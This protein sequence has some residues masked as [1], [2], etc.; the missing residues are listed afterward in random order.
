MRLGHDSTSTRV[1]PYHLPGLQPTAFAELAYGSPASPVRLRLPVATPALIAQAAPVLIGARDSYLAALPV[2]RI[3]DAVDGAIE[4]LL[5]RRHP[6]RRA[7][8]DLLPAVTG[9]SRPMIERGLSDLLKPFRRRGLLALLRAELRDPAVLDSPARLR[10]T[11]I[12]LA[13]N[14]PAVAVESAVHA[15]LVKSA[16]LVKPSSRD[17]VLP[18]LF[19]QALEE[20]DARLAGAVAVLWWKGGTEAL[21]CAALASA[22]AVIAYGGAAA[23]A[24]IRRLAPESARF[25]AYGPRVS[26]AAVGREA[27]AADGLA[28]LARKAAWDVGFFDQQGCVSPHAIYVERGGETG[29]LEFAGALARAMD[30]FQAR[31]P[32]GVIS[33]AAA[34]QVQQLRGAWEMRKAAGKPVALF[35]SAGSTAWTVAC[36]EEAF[37]LEPSCLNRVVMVI[38]L[39]DLADLPRAVS[40]LGPY[41]QTAGVAASRQRLKTLSPPLAA[42]GV[43]RICPIGRMQHPPASWCHDGQPN[44]LPLLP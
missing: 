5:D 32:R 23:L 37:E 18:A 40:G 2:A 19:A 12:I 24:S 17:P 10:L 41:L 22:G 7:A 27:L 11:T 16:C 26:L 38:P 31:Y 3:V 21:D 44:L 20:A 1:R 14:I 15:L 43:S 29:P 36:D 39:D 9:Y 28:R 30:E 6:L 13:G 8:E 25:I 33:P 35:Q 34:A 42:A 4:R